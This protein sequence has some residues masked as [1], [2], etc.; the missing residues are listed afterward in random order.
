MDLLRRTVLIA[1]VLVPCSL[2]AGAAG[3]VGQ[4]VEMLGERYGTPLPEGYRRAREADV[5]AFEFRRGWA[6]RGRGLALPD[7]PA[8]RSDDVASEPVLAL[9][10]RSGPVEGTFLVPVVLGLYENSGEPAPFTSSTIA[11]SYFGPGEGTITDYYDEVS[12]GRVELLGEVLE[13]VRAPRPD[14][15]Y[16][17]GESGIPGPPFPGLG[18]G[19]AWNFVYELLERLPPTDWGRYDNDGP[20]GIPNS[21]DDDGFV[22]VLAVIHP[23][24]GAECGGIDGPDRIW[25]H[26][27]ALSQPLGVAF[28]TSTASAN[29]GFIRIDDYTIQPAVACGGGQLSEIGVF[30]HELGHAFGLPD[31]YDT[32]GGHSG[33]GSWD[34]MSAG[35]WGCD[36]RSPEQP[37]HMGAWSKAALG[38]VDVVQ[39]PADT[40]QGVVTLAPV[41]QGGPVYRIDARDGSGEYY[42]LENRQRIGYDGSLRA[43]GLLVW[44]VDAG[45]V[46]R[47]WGSNRVNAGAHMGVWLRQADGLDD[48]GLGR[49]RGDDGDPYPGRTG[50]T[51]FHAVSEPSS[52][53]FAGD[54]SG[55]TIADIA[56]VGEN[57]SLRLSTRETVIAVRAEG[58]ASTD[59][60]FTL[61]GVPLTGL[62]ASFTSAPFVPHQLEVV[63]GD[64]IAPGARRSF[65]GWADD[66]SAA[67][68]RALV[69]PL[70]D[71][72]LVATFGGT[73]YELALAIS[74]G[75]AGIE[76]ASFL[77]EP[78]SE[79]LWFPAD[80]AVS[81]TAVPR[82]GFAFSGWS[83]ALAGQ[84]N[85]ARFTMAGPLQAGA[86]FE[87]T[88]AVTE[89]TIELP[90]ATNLDVQLLVEDGTAPV[91][92]RV[93]EGTLPLGVTLSTAGRITGASL[94][95]G[96]F[97]LTMEAVDASGL[98][99]TGVITLDLRS[100]PI[101]LEEAVSP[102]L[103]TG[104]TLD[105]AELNFL[106]R[107]GN[108]VAGYD[109]GD[110]RAWVLAD[111][112]QPLSADFDVGAVRRTVVVPAAR[113]TEPTR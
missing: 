41:E 1:S 56:I 39:L 14:T 7:F 63:A 99:A 58:A 112:T 2:G 100:P 67:R 106:N 45:L 32:D 47:T 16:T 22:D 81:L 18:G 23:T 19:G 76:P 3:A 89:A 30:T 38:W 15:A 87:L 26:R 34:L 110:F 68:Q 94:D 11:E 108:R 111:P 83:G 65:T 51:A 102:F 29:G 75:V 10:P 82:T 12:G 64:S 24:K 44:Q 33:V 4:D 57:V 62:S 90:A 35:S 17:V 104:N 84:P 28:T 97:D 107:Q 55:L 20:D 93:L 88:Y 43:A 49:G 40:D 86:D 8:A 59:G 6:A 46:S 61:D 36:D 74:G 54:W 85:P 69:T 77:A 95:V 27:W 109:V 101:L 53:S 78:A 21:G 9:G 70:A 66:P 50:N 31:L 37:C 73:E 60:L 42:L 71:A 79:D 103:L 5:G 25:S 72:E 91:R 13:W 52:Y 80:T 92:W 105:A 96:R 48:L 113:S 98:P